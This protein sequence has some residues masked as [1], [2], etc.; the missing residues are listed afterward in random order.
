MP[1]Q[2]F[3]STAHENH[4]RHR[5]HHSGNR[6]RIAVSPFANGYC[7]KCSVPPLYRIEHDGCANWAAAIASTELRGCEGFLLGIVADV[8]R[9]YDLPS[10]ST[11]EVVK[12]LLNGRI[13]TLLARSH[14]ERH[15][16]MEKPRIRMT[17]N[18]VRSKMIRAL[19]TWWHLHRGDDIPERIKLDPV[20]L[21]QLLKI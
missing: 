4:R 6:R 7:A 19:H 16:G 17:L 10:E 15:S 5:S 1:L 11:S 12:H 2:L 3:S 18:T 9:E 20:D 8:R 14:S 13:T 21:K